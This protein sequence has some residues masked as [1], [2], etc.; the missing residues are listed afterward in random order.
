MTIQVLIYTHYEGGGGG[1]GRC[2]W[3]DLFSRVQS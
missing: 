1:G 3:R 2:V